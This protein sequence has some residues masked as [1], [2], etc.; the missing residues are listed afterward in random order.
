MLV[1]T[2]TLDGLLGSV[3]PPTL[4][5]IDVEGAEVEVLRGAE[6]LLSSVRPVL[7]LET[8]GSTHSQCERI[9]QAAGYDLTKGAELNWLCLPKPTR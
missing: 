7:Y 2:I 6:R 8:V 1:P 9:L 3:L 5:K 4:V